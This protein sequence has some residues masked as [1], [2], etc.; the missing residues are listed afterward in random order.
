LLGFL[1]AAENV[2]DWCVSRQLWWGHRV[3][4]YKVVAEG[5][6]RAAT[7]DSDAQGTLCCAFAGSWGSY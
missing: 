5:E 2:E 1:C 6:T 7:E 3:P 4:A